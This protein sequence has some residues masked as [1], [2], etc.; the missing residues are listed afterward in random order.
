MLA[1]THWRPWAVTLA[2][3]SS[4][5]M[6]QVPA[7]ADLAGAYRHSTVDTVS[8]LYLLEDQTFCLAF[9]GGSLDL[10]AGGRWQM[11]ADGQS[12]SLQEVR[13]T[14]QRPVLPLF[15]RPPEGLL[16]SDALR[17]RTLVLDGRR[18]SFAQDVVIG[19]SPDQLRPVFSPAQH[20]FSS[21]YSLPLPRQARQLWVG[22]R[23][24]NQP[25]SY[26]V[27]GYPLT[28]KGTPFL[29]YDHVAHRPLLDLQLQRD[30][31]DLVLQGERF[32]KRSTPL[33]GSERES[34]RE[35]CQPFMHAGA[36]QQQEQ[37]DSLPQIAPLAPPIQ[38]PATAVGRQPWIGDTEEGEQAGSP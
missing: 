29:S 23:L 8:E 20:V 15:Q 36:A 35:A 30:Q 21:T 3:A 14:H 1:F 16:D 26:Q 5:A 13:D 11:A 25:D 9:M 4:G 22:Y 12:L 24:P 37:S 18:L 32:N 31:Q 10:L 28:N 7:P 19:F 33:A 38:L 6:A 17:P 2:L 34:I 27:Q